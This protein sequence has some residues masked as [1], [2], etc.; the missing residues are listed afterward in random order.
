MKKIHAIAFTLIL[1]AGCAGFWQG[2]KDTGKTINDAAGILCNLFAADHPDDLAGMTP[3]EWCA[4]HDNLKPFID[5]ALA[6]QQVAG[7]Q[8]LQ[9]SQ[10]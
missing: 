1:T 7:R 3:V 8:S 9:R 5:E 6:A 4:V 2:V 10:E